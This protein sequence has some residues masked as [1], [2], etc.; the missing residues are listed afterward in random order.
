[1]H[2]GEFF[3]EFECGRKNKDSPKMFI[4]LFLE[5]VNVLSSLAKGALHM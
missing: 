2:T 3:R 1:M 4:F 5:P